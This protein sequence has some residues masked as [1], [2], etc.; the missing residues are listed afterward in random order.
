[1]VFDLIFDVAMAYGNGLA[2]DERMLKWTKVE[3]PVIPGPPPGLRV[4]GFRD[5]YVI[6]NGGK[7]SQMPSPA[8]HLP[9]ADT[10]NMF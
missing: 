9:R 7:A 10:P 8:L 4:T 2:D 1:M 5:P 6:Q 3:Q